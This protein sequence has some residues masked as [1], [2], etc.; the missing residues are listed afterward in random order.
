MRVPPRT[1]W[2][3]SGLTK[4]CLADVSEP[5]I[6][7]HKVVVGRPGTRK[8]E[9]FPVIWVALPV[10][11]HRRRNDVSR[12]FPLRSRRL[13]VA[14]LAALFN[15]SSNRCRDMARVAIATAS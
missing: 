8:P 9:E 4:V 15:P 1:N 11:I 7:L 5:V 2:L 12:C 6:V 13:I 14:T 10:L 3:P